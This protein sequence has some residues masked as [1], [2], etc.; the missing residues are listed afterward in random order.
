RNIFANSPLPKWIYDF[1]TLRF[2]EVNKMAIQH[3]GYTE[4]E[5]LG[6]T[7]KDIR[8]REDHEK[9]SDD[10]LKIEQ[11]PDIR[12]GDWRHIKKNGEEIIVKISAHF[13]PYNGIKA[14]IVVVIDITDR[15]KAEQSK[16]F[17]SDNLSALINNT[18]DMM[19][20]VDKNL[21]LITSNDSFNRMVERLIG[22][23]IQPG[24]TVLPLALGNEW[25]KRY[26]GF[27]TKALGGEAFTIL[28]YIDIDGPLWSDISFYPIRQGNTV[29]GT[30]CFSRDITDSKKAQDKINSIEK[31]M[32]SLKIQA[33]KKVTRAIIKGQEHERNHIGRELH[34]NVNQL[35]ASAKL[36][37]GI[38]ANK[39][40][41]LKRLI[42]YP[43]ELIN[44]CVDEIRS[45]THG[46]VTPLKN[47][48][49]RET[50]QS[51]LDK[52]EN[53]SSIKTK[54]DYDH[55]DT[56][57]G[58]EL[59]LNLYRVIQEQLNN[60]VKHA[61]AKSIIVSIC[62]SNNEICLSIS[63]DGVG[64]NIDARRNGIGVSNMINR[65]EMFNGDLRIDSAPGAG[66]RVHVNIPVEA[67]K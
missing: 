44:N 6:M 15:V 42:E 58:D 34:D 31:R 55:M 40:P 21:K 38:A 33:Q 1:E 8:P 30:A 56:T 5:F 36:Y 13:I 7:I 60:I 10:L 9:L 53:G 64:F 66:C 37:L 11:E 45:L 35:L 49:L 20:S 24:E 17:A 25:V 28:E 52:V 48:D 19:W 14:R 63:D 39:N 59:K 57:I 67:L 4:E 12:N 61:H 3:Y 27:Y 65:V 18:R 2:L 54:L 16:Q 62:I 47:I 23:S 22:R 51:L 29:V 26:S 32:L 46:Y 50:V 43:V 41:R